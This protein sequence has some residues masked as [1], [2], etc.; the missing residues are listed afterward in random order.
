MAAPSQ[1]CMMDRPA[2]LPSVDFVFRGHRRLGIDAF[3]PRGRSDRRRDTIRRPKMTSIHELARYCKN[4]AKE[5]VYRSSCGARVRCDR[6]GS[7]PSSCR[8][9]EH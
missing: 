9:G 1:T 5:R 8:P 3:L 2:P 6:A 7:P 4:G